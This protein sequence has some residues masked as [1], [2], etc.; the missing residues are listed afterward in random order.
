MHKCS[1]YDY[2]RKHCLPSQQMDEKNRPFLDFIGTDYA[3]LVVI[4]SKPAALSDKYAAENKTIEDELENICET[5][6]ISSYIKLL[7]FRDE[8]SRNWDSTIC[9]SQFRRDLRFELKNIAFL[10]IVKC[11]TITNVANLSKTVGINVIRTCSEK[12][13]LNQLQILN[14]KYIIVEYKTTW[15]SLKLTNFQS[16]MEQTIVS[17]SGNRKIPLNDRLKNIR[18]IFSEFNDSLKRLKN[19]YD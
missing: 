14:P 3:G 2:C 16:T 17:Y 8:T 6:D 15:T 11:R 10:N 13:L 7:N 4:S 9:R 19:N 12:F 18:P 1:N 5:R